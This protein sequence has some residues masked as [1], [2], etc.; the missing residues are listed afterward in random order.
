MA[1]IIQLTDPVTHENVYPVGYAQGGCKMDL[2]WTNPNPDVAFA[3]QTI[4]LDLSE[5]QYV[6]IETIYTTTVTNSEIA[7]IKNNSEARIVSLSAKI[8]YR[9]ATVSNSSIVFGNAS[10][11]NT[12]GTSSTDNERC[13][14]YKIYGI[15]TSYIVPTEVHG[16]QYIGDDEN[17]TLQ[18]LIGGDLY[19]KA[20]LTWA[21]TEN[22]LSTL[23][24]SDTR[25]EATEDCFAYIVMSGTGGSTSF[26][27]CGIEMNLYVYGNGHNNLIPMK[28]GQYIEVANVGNLSGTKIF[29]VKH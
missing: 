24:S 8:S 6:L 7:I 4:S 9:D 11:M 28:K 25:Y 20:Q 14:P 1:N 16:L 10:F 19:P 5:Y 29:G 13:I 27:Y 2:L 18:N 21:D 26:K 12:Y 3:S 15:K 23:T 22:V 17:I